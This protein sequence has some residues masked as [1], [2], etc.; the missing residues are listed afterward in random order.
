[1]QPPRNS[2]PRS[3]RGQIV[4]CDEVCLPLARGM[5]EACFLFF[6]VPEC[7]FLFSSRRAVQKSW[8]VWLIAWLSAAGV[9]ESKVVA[10]ANKSPSALDRFMWT[11]T[12]HSLRYLTGLVGPG[13]GVEWRGEDSAATHSLRQI[14]P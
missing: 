7:V 2:E 13:Q 11:Q 10:T 9:E 4:E 5:K 8:L 12:Y 14:P 6:Q 1:M 3:E